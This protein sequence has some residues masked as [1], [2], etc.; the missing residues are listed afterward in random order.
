MR[1]LNRNHG[2]KTALVLVTLVFA[3]WMT[4][5]LSTRA[6]SSRDPIFEDYLNDQDVSAEYESRVPTSRYLIEP[7]VGYDTMVCSDLGAVLLLII[8]SYL[9]CRILYLLAARG[10]F[11]ENE[12]FQFMIDRIRTVFNFSGKYC[13]LVFLIELIIFLI[14][15]TTLGFLFVNHYFMGFLQVW[16]LI[17]LLLIVGKS[18]YVIIGTIHPSIKVRVKARKNWMDKSKGIYWR[19][20]IINVFARE[21]RYFLFFFVLSFVATYSL[22]STE[23][24]TQKFETDLE[25]GEMLIDFHVHTTMSDGALSPEERVRWYLDQGIHAAAFSDHQNTR[26]A[27]A[28]REYV[29]RN[30]LDFIVITA[31]EYTT[32]EQ[33]GIHM[34]IYGIDEDITP[35][36]FA[37]D[38]LAR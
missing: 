26:G 2:W 18:I 4:F 17:T 32:Y 38:P 16:F 23:L 20:K 36:E 15:Y 7:L 13:F 21:P 34:N 8:L 24:P 3:C 1:K 6:N 30:N 19:H 9:V 28:A 37:D 29:E 27:K 14:G 5:I 35:D 25:D 22:I 33:P 12:K 31:Q 11:H 10:L